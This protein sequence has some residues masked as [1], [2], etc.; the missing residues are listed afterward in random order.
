MKYPDHTRL[1]EKC[2]V[3]RIEEYVVKRRQN[4]RTFITEERKELWEEAK[5]TKPPARDVRKIL[6]W[7]QE[8]LSSEDMG[9]GE[10]VMK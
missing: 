2:G 10:R 9:Q 6:W 5:R 7:N 4:L 3:Q 1:R 8:M